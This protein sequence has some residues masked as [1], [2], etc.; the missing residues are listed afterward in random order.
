MN[1]FT[2]SLLEELDDSAFRAWAELWDQLE[3]LVVEVYRAQHVG[4]EEARGYR[5]LRAKL[6][7]RYPDWQEALAPY[8][9]GLKAGGEP[10]ERD[11]FATLFEPQEAE[12]FLDNWPSMQRL[13]AAREALN[14]YLLDQLDA[15]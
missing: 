3:S 8:W 1:P 4:A 15:A 5:H 9:Q 14:A 12:E 10:V 6:E 13:P 7:A 2:R 11:P